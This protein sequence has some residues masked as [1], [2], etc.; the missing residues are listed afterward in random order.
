MLTCVARIGKWSILENFVVEIPISP[1]IYFQCEKVK[2]VTVVDV[3]PK[4]PF[5]MATTLRFK[6][7]R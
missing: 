7:D 4:L 6:K 1:G 5:S 3:D 2:F